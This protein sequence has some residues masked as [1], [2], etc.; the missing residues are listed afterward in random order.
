MNRMHI[1]IDNANEDDKMCLYQGL[2]DNREEEGASL[3]IKGKLRD[4]V[5][6]IQ[7]KGKFSNK[8]LI[9]NLGQLQTSYLREKGNW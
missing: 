8:P 5:I 1:K 7:R 2:K 9:T 4:N 6:L 3:A